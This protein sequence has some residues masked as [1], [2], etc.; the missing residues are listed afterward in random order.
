MGRSLGLS[1]LNSKKGNKYFFA[2]DSLIVSF[3]L[4]KQINFKRTINMF[5][6]EERMV[7]KKDSRFN[8]LIEKRRGGG[9]RFNSLNDSLWLK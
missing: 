4:R 1:G 6:L 5:H 9:I 3:V 8:L 2:I 7:W